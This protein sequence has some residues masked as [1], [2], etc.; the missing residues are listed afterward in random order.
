MKKLTSYIKVGICLSAVALSVSCTKDFTDLNTNPGGVTD[1]E[2]MGDFA[3][4]AAFLAQGQRAIISEN[5]GE[6]QLSNN[7]TSDAYGGYFAA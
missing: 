3:L 1:E 2:A 5:V 6:Y 7:L 4:Y